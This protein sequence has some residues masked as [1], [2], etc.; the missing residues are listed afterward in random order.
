[1]CFYKWLSINPNP[2]G[3]L[4]F[5]MGIQNPNEKKIFDNE[6]LFTEFPPAPDCQGA[7]SFF[8]FCFFH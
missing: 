6:F 2:L 4:D 1:M 8:V 5:Y 7:L 3:S